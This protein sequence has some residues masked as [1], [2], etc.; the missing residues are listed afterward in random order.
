VPFVKGYF[1]V[2]PKG[3]LKPSE[4]GAKSKMFYFYHMVAL[5]KGKPMEGF[6]K[7]KK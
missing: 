5:K 2:K 7:K 4:L 1:K 6:H 3:L